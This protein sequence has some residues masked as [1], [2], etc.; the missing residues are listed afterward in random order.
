MGYHAKLSPSGA[1][2]W[3]DCTASPGQSAGKPNESS[4]A[5]RPGTA[6][7]QAGAECLEDGHDPGAYLGRVMGFPVEG[8]EGWL[9]ELPHS[10]LANIKHRYTVDAIGVNALRAYVDYVRELHGAIGG[11]LIVER[12]V[13]IDHITGEPNATGRSDVIIL[14][15]PYA[16]VCDAKFGRKKVRAYDVIEPASVDPLTGEETPEQR[17]MNLQLAMY[18]EG[19][20][21]AYGG[22][23]AYRVVRAVI[24]QPMID[25]VSEHECSTL[26]LMDITGW[27]YERAKATREQPEFKPTFD[28]C[29]FC[30]GK[31]DCP[32]RAAALSSTYA[33]GFED[34]PD[35]VDNADLF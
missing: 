17:R 1:S 20:L 24:V 6:L 32:A 35:P 33:D 13:P 30:A 10:A 14:A 8:D 5:S 3:A 26:E 4:A 15:P 2:R 28:N 31:I 11:R 18:A 16:I 9:D 12:D 7:H 22:S 27:L 21:H 25:S 19:A 34:V 23:D 29:L